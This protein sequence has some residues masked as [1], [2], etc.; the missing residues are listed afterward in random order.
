MPAPIKNGTTTIELIKCVPFNG[1]TEQILFK[2]IN[3]Q[4][5]YFSCR[6]I[7]SLWY[8]EQGKEHRGSQIMSHLSY[9]RY[10]YTARLNIDKETIY[11]DVNYMRFKN[12]DK[13]KWIYAYITEIHWNNSKECDVL[14]VIDSWQT[15]MFNIRWKACL[16]DREHTNEDLFGTNR[17]KEDINFTNYIEKS[18]ELRNDVV[19]L[20]DATGEVSNQ[21]GL[22]S[23]SHMT[24]AYIMQLKPDFDFAKLSSFD[25]ISRLSIS[26]NG[27]ASN[28]IYLLF[29]NAQQLQ[30]FCA[31]MFSVGIRSEDYEKIVSI[32]T[33]PLI[34]FATNFKVNTLTGDNY[35]IENLNIIIHKL[36]FT[37]GEKNGHCYQILDAKNFTN[38][39]VNGK[40]V[41]PTEYNKPYNVFSNININY[42]STVKN[43]KS[44]YFPN[45]TIS[46]QTQ[47]DT[48][49]IKPEFLA[50]DENG[51]VSISFDFEMTIFN[52]AYTLFL[53][54][55]NGFIEYDTQDNE[56]RHTNAFKVTLP[57]MPQ[58]SAY[59]DATSQWWR[60]NG[61]KTIA[62]LGIAAA[63]IAVGLG[64]IGSETVAGSA[65]AK[66]AA[67][68]LPTTARGGMR[69]N[70]YRNDYQVM[71]GAA[72]IVNEA[73]KIYQGAITSDY[74][75]GN[76]SGI[77]VMA[78]KITMA[79]I[80]VNYLIEEEIQQCDDF[81][82]L[83]GYSRKKLSLP[84]FT[85]PVTTDVTSDN[86]AKDNT[87]YCKRKYWYYCKM[88]NCNISSP[89]NIIYKSNY[90]L[91]NASLLSNSLVPLNDINAIKQMF[92]NG[93]TLWLFSTDY[94]DTFDDNILDYSLD[95]SIIV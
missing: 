49:N 76:M 27:V 91:Q 41:K 36:K 34:A 22:F 8:D 80:C 33:I 10:Q 51:N 66:G 69:S 87:Y 70:N 48:V 3:D 40:E 94:E 86:Y 92:M 50:P 35:W 18:Y 45:T 67:L 63:S 89:T 44:L 14:F 65:M 56:P 77:D 31:A 39:I 32:Y 84:A 16:I 79:K 11:D 7:Q 21:K 4:N 13:H 2:N 59:A 60:Q 17:E 15:Y 38:I 12:S 54:D 37:S 82:K 42:Y 71:G 58:V 26:Q 74:E 85:T 75:I 78:S 46:L 20:S 57:I 83:Y 23:F 24:P 19:G 81:Y 28:N 29:F 43:K 25:K 30:L 62:A 93:I 61:F 90:Y 9:Q 47:V 6:V 55:Y 1:E 52:T 88:V 5:R 72:S 68:S 73:T 64:A 53:K 95:N